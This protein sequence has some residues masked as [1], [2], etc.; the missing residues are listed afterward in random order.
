MSTRRQKTSCHPGRTP[1]LSR[2]KSRDPGAARTAL[3]HPLG[4][5]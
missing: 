2:R 5:G 1:A 3:R 4:P